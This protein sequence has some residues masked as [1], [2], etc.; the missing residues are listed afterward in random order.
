MLKDMTCCGPGESSAAIA[1]GAYD[2]HTSAAA[3]RAT[4]AGALRGA[5]LT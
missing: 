1:A 4:T 2:E 5:G 3:A